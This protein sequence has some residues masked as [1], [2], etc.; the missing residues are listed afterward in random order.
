MILGFKTKI[1]GKPTYFVEKIQALLLEVGRINNNYDFQRDV[2]GFVYEHLKKD[3][4]EINDLELAKRYASIYPKLH[5]IRE[6][7]TGRWKPGMMID[8]FI[9]VRTKNMF[10]FAPGVPVVS[11]QKIEI[12]W[13][14]DSRNLELSKLA[15]KRFN[16]VDVIVD[17]NILYFEDV[18]LLAQND[19]FNDIYDFFFYFNQDFSGKII[20]WTDKQY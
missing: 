5:T 13:H 16:Y 17:N 7:K 4:N 6:D 2:A 1:N 12:V 3:N 11:I 14:S 19:G 18:K 8:F 9:N 10:R 15:P 20:H